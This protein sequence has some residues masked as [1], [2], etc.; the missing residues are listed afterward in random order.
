MQRIFCFTAIIAILA[1]G[2]CHCSRQPKR[3]LNLH[4]DEIGALVHDGMTQEAVIAALGEPATQYVPES[5][6]ADLTFRYDNSWV[7]SD[8]YSYPISI[9]IYFNEGVVVTILSQVTAR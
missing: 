4:V 5:N 6:S 2:L 8:N 7:R 9:V 3:Y 1:A